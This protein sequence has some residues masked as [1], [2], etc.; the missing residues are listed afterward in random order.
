MNNLSIFDTHCHLADKEYQQQS[1]TIRE[2]IQA[3]AAVGVKCILNVG[4][5]KS[6]NQKVIEQLKE[7]A[8]LYGALGLHPNSNEDLTEENLSWIERQLVHQRIIAIGEIGLD[9]YRTFTDI[10]K[11]KYWFKRQLKLAKKYNL[12]VLLHIREA[13]A[14]AY[15][16]VKESGIKK[17][18]LHCF[19][20]NWE[21]AEKFINLG[22]Y[23]SFAGNITYK[24]A[25]WQT[26][27]G[28]VIEKIP[29]ERIVVETD[30]PYLTPEPF[31]GRINYPQHIIHTLTKIAEIK[32]MDIKVAAEKIYL[33][34]LRVLGINLPK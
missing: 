26:R 29:L 3:A 16:M 2:I 19:T 21:I 5:D 28:E 1:R 8:N 31:R 22:F 30:A 18:I 34:T 17:G 27:W 33:N 25:K 6:S 20:G 15:E 10:D 24:T 7:F 23:V 4:Y 14:D 13:F 12:P 32:K 11:Q 9:F